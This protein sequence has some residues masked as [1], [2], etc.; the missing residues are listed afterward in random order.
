MSGRA[1]GLTKQQQGVFRFI[2][3]AFQGLLVGDILMD[4]FY[5]KPVK[6][7]DGVEPVNNSYSL[8]QQ[9]IGRMPLVCMHLFVSSYNPLFIQTCTKPDASTA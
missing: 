7:N 9:N 1:E 5:S 2:H 3:S 4:M 8:D 6:I